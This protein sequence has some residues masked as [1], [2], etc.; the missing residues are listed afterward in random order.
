MKL[1][2]FRERIGATQKETAEAI[3]VTE[4]TLY[5]WSTGKVIPRPITLPGIR[6]GLQKLIAKLVENSRL[7]PCEVPGL[8][9]QIDEIDLLQGEK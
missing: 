6:K 4:Q 9:E 8:M 7:E 2:K 5:V 1:E 3:G